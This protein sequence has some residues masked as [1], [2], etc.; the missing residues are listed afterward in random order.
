MRRRQHN[1][2]S[3]VNNSNVT[4]ESGSVHE[5]HHRLLRATIRGLESQ[6]TGAKVSQ[7]CRPLN[8]ILNGTSWLPRASPGWHVHLE[9]YQLPPERVMLELLASKSVLPRHTVVK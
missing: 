3:D 2:L 8:D 4:G 5:H 1:L 9:L 7:E 6:I